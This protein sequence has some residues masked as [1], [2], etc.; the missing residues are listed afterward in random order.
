MGYTFSHFREGFLSSC[1]AF[2]PYISLLGCVSWFPLFIEESFFTRNDTY[3]RGLLSL[4]VFLMIVDFE[5]IFLECVW[6]MTLLEHNSMQ[7]LSP[8]K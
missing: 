4:L 8:M 6:A 3:E 2:G 5:V 7:K 1:L